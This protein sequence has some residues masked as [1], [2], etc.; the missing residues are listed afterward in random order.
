MLPYGETFFQSEVL[1]ILVNSPP[2]FSRVPG[3]VWTPF[4][5]DCCSLSHIHFTIWLLLTV[6]TQAVKEPLIF[7]RHNVQG[8]GA[9]GMRGTAITAQS[10]QR[11]PE[12]MSLNKMA[13][14]SA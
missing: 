2:S 9:L 3:V 6:T 8:E 5:H 11:I 12:Q 1:A 10:H 13:A 4:G 7:G 14:R